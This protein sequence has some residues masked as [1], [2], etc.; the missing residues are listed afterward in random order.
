VGQVVKV[1]GVLLGVLAVGA[2]VWDVVSP[3]VVGGTAAGQAGMRVGGVIGVVLRTLVL[4]ALAFWLYGKGKALQSP[5]THGAEAMTRRELEEI[6][7]RHADLAVDM[8]IPSS[9]YASTAD[10]ELAEIYGT[11]D[12]NAAPERFRELIGEI[13]RRVA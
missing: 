4:G 1:L 3:D 5:A 9:M 2:V 11:M 13:R 10:A 8:T 7:A 12:K 6:V